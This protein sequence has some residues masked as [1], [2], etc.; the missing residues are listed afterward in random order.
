MNDI[1]SILNQLKRPRLLI[2]AARAGA[3]DYRR[4]PHLRRLLGFGKLPRSGAA[5]M[6][7]VDMEETLND[8]RVAGDADYSLVKHVD[9]LIAIM[10]EARLLQAAYGA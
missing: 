9:V 5:I 8:A 10:G 1:L 2:Q 4:D 6:R 3:E 7:L